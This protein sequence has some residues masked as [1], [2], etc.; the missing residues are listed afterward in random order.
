MARMKFRPKNNRSAQRARA[1]S[2]YRRGTTRNVAKAKRAS[3]G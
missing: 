3:N 2:N 1:A